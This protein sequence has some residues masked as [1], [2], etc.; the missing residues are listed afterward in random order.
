MCIVPFV[1]TVTK[2]FIR[3][4]AWVLFES[5]VFIPFAS[6][7]RY[8]HFIH[9]FYSFFEFQK[10]RQALVLSWQHRSF[11]FAE[12]SFSTSTFAQLAV[13]S[14]RFIQHHSVTLHSASFLL[15]HTSLH[16]FATLMVPFVLAL[17]G[18]RLFFLCYFESHSFVIITLYDLVLLK[19]FI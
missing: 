18:S 9:L 19:S 13:G 4:L 6:F 14:R 16:H 10:L 1:P 5:R 3:F 17:A 12:A 8:W 2:H 15:P 7:L 11:P